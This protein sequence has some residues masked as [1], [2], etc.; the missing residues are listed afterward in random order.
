MAD[1]TYKQLEDELAKILERVEH[2]SYDELD[3][4]LKDYDAGSKI[5]AALQ[6]KLDTA[7]NK[8]NKVN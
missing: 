5:I 7:K 1:K 4:L 8:I 2:A 3:D 6:K